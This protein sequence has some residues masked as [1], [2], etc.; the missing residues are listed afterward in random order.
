MTAS[1]ASDRIEGFVRPP[2][3]SSPLPS[4]SSEPRSIEVLVLDAEPDRALPELFLQGLDELDEG[5]RV[6]VKVIDEGLSLADRGG[7]DLEDVGQAVPHDLE[8]LAAIHR[9][10]LDVGLG[11]H[12]ISL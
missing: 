11:G 7:L 4:R 2:A 12:S 3:A 9:P 1:S 8:D 6:R 10:L 5:E